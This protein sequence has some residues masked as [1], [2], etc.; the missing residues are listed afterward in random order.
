MEIVHDIYLSLGSNSGNREENIQQAIS[1]VNDS[2][3]SVVSCATFFENAAQGFHSDTLFLNTC[4]CVKSDIDHFSLLRKIKEIE[5]SLGR[6][7]KTVVGY[8]SRTI[9]IDIILLDNLVFSNHDLTIPHK[10]F[11]SRDFVLFPLTEIAPDVIDPVSSLTS[12]QLLELLKI[13]E[14]GHFK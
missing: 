14:S 6:K 7:P 13:N 12:Q 9:D 5:E 10:L 3:G 4:I 8:E 11:R 2:I 1:K